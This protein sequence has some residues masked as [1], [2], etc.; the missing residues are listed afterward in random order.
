MMNGSSD[1]RRSGPRIAPWPLRR[2]FLQASVSIDLEPKDVLFHAGDRGDG[3][4]LLRRGS[5]KAAVVARDG[6]E[7]LL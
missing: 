7:R 3:C 2:I 5:A 6:Q 1:G 4:Y